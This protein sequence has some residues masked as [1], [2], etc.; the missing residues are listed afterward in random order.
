MEKKQP[1]EMISKHTAQMD[2]DAQLEKRETIRQK[3]Y[4]KIVPQ[5]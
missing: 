3:M 4:L 1:E 2:S 5:L